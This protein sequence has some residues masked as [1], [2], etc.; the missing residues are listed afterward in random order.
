VIFS[1]IYIVVFIEVFLGSKNALR[2]QTPFPEGN[3]VF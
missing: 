3:A 2:G 1:P